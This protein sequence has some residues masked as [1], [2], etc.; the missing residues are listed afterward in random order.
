MLGAAD[1][2]T[3]ALAPGTPIDIQGPLGTVLA[4]A[5]PRLV[6][7]TNAPGGI[8]TQTALRNASTLAPDDEEAASALNTLIAR[9]FTSGSISLRGDAHGWTLGA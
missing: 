3:V 7:V 2:V 4:M 9:T 6:V 5:H 1:V 8:G